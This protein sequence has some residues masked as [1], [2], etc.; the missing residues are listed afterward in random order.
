M[1]VPPPGYPP[2]RQPAI[3]L[4]VCPAFLGAFEDAQQPSF[5]VPFNQCRSQQFV[6]RA[7]FVAIFHAADR[8]ASREFLRQLRSQ[9]PTEQ[10]AVGA[11]LRF[12]AVEP[13]E[14]AR[15]SNRLK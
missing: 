14:Q 15:I 9:R 6:G 12:G 11:S 3:R 2:A 7:A 10:T 13:T 5:R 4:G 1:T 8:A